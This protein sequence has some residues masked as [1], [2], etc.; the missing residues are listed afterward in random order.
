MSKRKSRWDSDSDDDDINNERQMA[1]TNPTSSASKVQIHSDTTITTSTTT[2]SS[3]NTQ[4]G[5]PGHFDESAS[6]KSSK[7]S[8]T[9]NSSSKSDSP[10]SKRQRTGSNPL[11]EPSKDLDNAPGADGETQEDSS[12]GGDG[13]EGEEGVKVTIL[14]DS[15]AVKVAAPDFRPSGA[16]A[17]EQNTV[18]GVVVKFSTPSEA[19]TP[20]QKWRL[21]VFKGEEQVE[22]P[23]PL[24][25][26]PW[27]L[28]GRDRAVADIPIDHPSCSKQ[29]AVICHRRVRKEDPESGKSVFVERPYI[30]DLESTHHTTLAGDNLKPAR[31][32]ELRDRDVIKFGMSTREYVLLAE[33]A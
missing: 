21:Y 3:S 13:G 11:P 16:L 9:N 14:S 2:S 25:A 28:I 31:F 29:H 15:A 17:A 24:S 23:I 6:N 7:T 30:I 32:Y 33:E 12:R 4:E 10:A 27:Y 26:Q 18:N 22:K 5:V 1:H 19:V 8:T 20:K